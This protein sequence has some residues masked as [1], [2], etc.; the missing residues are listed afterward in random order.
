MAD[1]PLSPPLLEA[2]LAAAQRGWYVLPIYPAIRDPEGAGVSGICSCLLGRECK[3]TGKHPLATLVPNGQNDSTIDPAKIRNW[4]TQ[5]PDASVAIVLIPSGLLA[6]DIDVYHG[7]DQKLKS[8]L[9]EHGD[10]PET[11]QQNSGSGEGVHLIFKAPGVPIRGNIGGIVTR[12]RNYILIAPSSHKSGKQYN[13]EEGYGPGE[14]EPADLPAKWVRALS[15]AEGSIEGIAIIPEAEEPEWLRQISQAERIADMRA[16]VEAEDP[17]VMGQTLP[18]MMFNVARS[19]ARGFAIRDPNAVFEALRD[20]LNPRCVPPYDLNKLA[21]RVYAA[22]EKAYAPSWGESLQLRALLEN[23]KTAPSPPTEEAL[24]GTLRAFVRRTA[25]TKNAVEMH[26]H[27][28]VDRILKYKLGKPQIENPTEILFIAETLVN[29]SPQGTK[30]DQIAVKLHGLV[31]GPS[32]EDLIS[33]VEGIKRIDR[34]DDANAPQN[35]EEVRGLLKVTSKGVK[36]SPSN[37]ALILRYSDAFRD[38]LMFN[39]ITRMIEIDESSGPS[40]F[41]AAARLGKLDTEIQ[42]WLENKWGM[43]V[44]KEAVGDILDFI[45]RK[46]GSFDPVANYLD[47]LVWDGKE[48][49]DHW[50]STYCHVKDSKYTRLIGA[51]WMISAAARGL[52]PGCK[53]DTVLVLKGNQGLKKSSCFDILGGA[54]FS[55]SSLDLANKDARIT[56]AST[57]IIELPELAA[58][59]QRDLEMNKAFIS[60]RKD[61]VR[62]PYGK[63]DVEFER[64]CVFAGSTNANEFLID[65]TG[66]RR[67]WIAKVEGYIDTRGLREGRDQLWAE[68]VVRFREAMKRQAE[69]GH[70]E[71]E[72]G[73]RYRWWF[74]GEEQRLAD[75]EAKKSTAQ[76]SWVDIIIRWA[77][78]QAA[79]NTV[80]ILGIPQKTPQ[81]HNAWTMGD[82]AK[83]ALEIEA[84]E[85]PRFDKQL[86]RALRSAGFRDKRV[87]LGS[88]KRPR[89]WCR[90]EGGGGGGE[91]IDVEDVSSGGGGAEEDDG[92]GPFVE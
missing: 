68:A 47:G 4:W 92:G 91:K 32:I 17:E 55:D 38:R 12:S 26:K 82:I 62:P 89:L 6:L 56:A 52:S 84:K 9:I 49:I 25:H 44:S 70:L 57:W 2:A 13:W 80:A 78:R 73:A 86:A 72:D 16:H 77:D 39:E 50:L 53:V 15:K 58:L 45:S 66:N 10:L 19:S 90:E 40:Q 7:D 76:D 65:E 36:N 5:R 27:D 88:G 18:G 8:L 69:K 46:Y 51:R 33:L 67:F 83:G 31:S 61:K 75:V 30:S 11:I 87:D 35:D 71:D 37:I 60:G 59:G 79:G 22:Y 42:I 54:W 74:E 41:A 20:L 48:R 1:P 23:T 3:S 21:E 29:V 14:I 28:V 85:L 24:E 34:P 81:M 63:T 64:H 43:D